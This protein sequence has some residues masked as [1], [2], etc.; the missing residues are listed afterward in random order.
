MIV[1]FLTAY[2]GKELA[3]FSWTLMK[4]MAILI[5]SLIHI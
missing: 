2:I 4:V 3:Y 5:L 1:D